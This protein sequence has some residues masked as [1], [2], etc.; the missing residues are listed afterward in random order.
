MTDASI[1]EYREARAPSA[2]PVRLNIHYPERQRRLTNFPFFVGYMIR[3]LL[4]TPHLLLLYPLCY[5]QFLAYFGSTFVITFRGR[6]PRGL[7]K[8]QVGA[9]RWQANIS[10]YYLHLFDE[11]P[12]LDLDQRP[13]RAL[14]FEVDYPDTP[15]RWLNAP[16]IGIFIKFVLVSP[17]LL[18]LYGFGFVAVVVVF[19]SEVAILFTGRFP[20][21]IF[22]LVVGYVRWTYRVYGYL[23]GFTDRYPPF[24]LS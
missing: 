7:F 11:Y 10:G 2:Y 15:S 9:L 24:S 20:E 12:P 4:L 3:V 1:E 8:L 17:H 14:Q 16:F 21:G 19:I 13:E 23:S 18:I 6:Y 22:N 5:L